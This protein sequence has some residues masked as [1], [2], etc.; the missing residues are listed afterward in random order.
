MKK[1]KRGISS[2]EIILVVIIM[3]LLMGVIMIATMNVV[4]AANDAERKSNIAQIMKILLAVRINSGTFPVEESECDVGKNCYNLDEA[5]RK[6]KLDEI[7]K[8]PK[9]GE[10]YYRYK[11]NGNSFTIKC[12]MADNSEYVYDSDY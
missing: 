7:P 11:S 4:N 3:F 5:L 1:I 8:D 6:Q 10:N 9:G 2:I 12:W